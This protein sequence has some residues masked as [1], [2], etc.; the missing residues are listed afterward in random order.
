MASTYL[1]DLRSRQDGLL[2]RLI[3]HVLPVK[4]RLTQLCAWLVRIG[5][6]YHP[7]QPAEGG[8]KLRSSMGLLCWEHQPQIPFL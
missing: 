1:K 8:G 2:E 4:V 3:T 6:F 5:M 7:L